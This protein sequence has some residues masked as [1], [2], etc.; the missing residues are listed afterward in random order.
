MC[1]EKK[2]LLD[3]D[4]GPFGRRATI[5]NHINAVSGIPSV[6]HRPWVLV[7]LHPQIARQVK[8]AVPSLRPS[9]NSLTHHNALGLKFKLNG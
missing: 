5:V 1:A 6:T 3:A 7:S 9:W 4:W 2:G 8:K